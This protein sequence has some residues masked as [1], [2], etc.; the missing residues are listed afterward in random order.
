MTSDQ[1][2][3]QRSPVGRAV[4]LVV[5]L[6][7]VAVAASSLTV[8]AADFTASD[9]SVESSNG[10]LQSLTVEP[11]GT[12]SYHGFEQQPTA[13]TVDVQV[14]VDGNWKTIGTQT[15][16]VNDLEG[17]FEYDFGT[18]SV[19]DQTSDGLT[20]DQFKARPQSPTTTSVE[21]RI[22]VTF[23]GV[24]AGGSDLVLSQGD[25]F[26]VTVEHGGGGPPG[27]GPGNGG[28]GNSGG[29]SQ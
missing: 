20:A 13:T 18:I 24:S 6:G 16:A 15:V 4:A 27:G 12:V 3:W 21:I 7:V 1:R 17:S 22:R 26:S 23:E 9:V 28:G 2:W 19:L 25:T 5:V 14:R 29:P 11:A 8:A 10:K